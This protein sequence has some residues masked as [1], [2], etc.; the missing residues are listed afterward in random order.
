MF[1]V[2]AKK[3][4]SSLRRIVGG[5]DKFVSLILRGQNKLEVCNCEDDSL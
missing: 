1:A 5:L 2:Y 4:I 3:I